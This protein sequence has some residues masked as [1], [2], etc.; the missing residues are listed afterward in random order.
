MDHSALLV[1]LKVLAH[2]NWVKIKNQL[3]IHVNI[4]CQ[5]ILTM[6]LHFHQNNTHFLQSLLL[7]VTDDNSIYSQR[8]TYNIQPVG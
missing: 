5:A 4:D 8:S 1:R 7:T 3:S 2:I 6:K